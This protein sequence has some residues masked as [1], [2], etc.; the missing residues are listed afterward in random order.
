[1]IMR[2]DSASGTCLSADEERELR[3]K[4]QSATTEHRIVER[5]KIVLL[6]HEGKTNLEIAE[7]LDTSPV[8]VSKWRRRFVEAGLCGLLDEEREGRPATYDRETDR[9]V[10]ALLDE[11]HQRPMGSGPGHC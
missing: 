3:T 5:A 7:E 8:R 11:P 1:M 10:L 4:T 6:A 9:R 2:H